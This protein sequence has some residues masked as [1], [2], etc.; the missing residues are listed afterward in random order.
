MNQQINAH[1]HSVFALEQLSNLGS[2][3]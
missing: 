1:R 3:Q 2:K